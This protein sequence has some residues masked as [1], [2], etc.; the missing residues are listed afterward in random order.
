MSRF[1]DER[2]DDLFYWTVNVGEY[3]SRNR[4]GRARSEPRFRRS[5]KRDDHF[6]NRGYPGS[7][8]RYELFECINRNQ[9]VNK[10]TLKILFVFARKWLLCPAPLLIINNALG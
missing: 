10:L 9:K 4:S 3:Q 6:R 1:M 7:A 8:F 5:T 2:L